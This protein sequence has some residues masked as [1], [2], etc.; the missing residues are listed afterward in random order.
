[1]PVWVYW[2]MVAAV[3]YSDEVLAQGNNSDVIELAEDHIAVVRV[4]EHQ[5]ARQQ[6][7]EEVKDVVQQALTRERAQEQLAERAKGLLAQLE[8]GETLAALSDAEKLEAQTIS[9]AGRFN[10]E[11]DRSLM[12]FVFTMVK[13]SDKPSAAF[14]LASGDYALVSLSITAGETSAEVAQQQAQSLR[15]SQQ[16]ASQEYDPIVTA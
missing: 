11:V 1:M 5:P 9:A 12:E 15:L 10:A 2:L 14:T 6:V 7:L 3:L 4:R 13:P 16:L 8:A